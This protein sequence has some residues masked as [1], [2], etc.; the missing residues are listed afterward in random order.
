MRGLGGPSRTVWLF[1]SAALILPQAAWAQTANNPSSPTTNTLAP[2]QAPPTQAQQDAARTAAKLP[3]GSDVP[4]SPPADQ[5]TP[6]PMPAPVDHEALVPKAVK[7][8][9]IEEELIPGRRR[10]GPGRA[11]LDGRNVQFNIGA[12][13]PPELEDFHGAE[14][15]VIPD[16]WRLL[17]ALCPD[18]G[19]RAVQAA[20][21]SSLDPYHQNTLKGDRPLCHATEEENRKR[22]ENH[23]PRCI[24]PGFLHGDDWFLTLSAISDTIVEPRS[25]PLPVGVQTTDRPDSNDLFGRS[26]SFVFAQTVIASA[27]LVKGSTAYMP[28]HIEYKIALAYQYNYADVQE[29]RILNVRPSFPTHRSDAFLGV[30][31]LFVDYH[32]RNVSDRYDFDSLRVGIQPFNVDFRGFLFTDSN[33]GIRLFGNR[34][35]NR[36]QYNFAAFARLEKDSNSGLNDVTQNIRKDYVFAANLYRQ[37]FPVPGYTSQVAVVYNRNR[38]GDEIQ[39]DHNGFP[40]RPALLGDLRGREYDAYYLGYNGEGH[41]DRLNLSLS[42]YGVFGRDRNSFFTSRPANIRAFFLAAEPS[43][44]TNFIRIRGSAVYASGDGNPY[45]NT[46][47]GFDSILENPLIA[48]SDTSYF[49]RQGIPF[50]G[51]GR[52]ISFSGRNGLLNDLRSSKDEGQSNFNNPGTILAGLG[53]DI[54]VLP[55]FRVTGNANHIWFANT[56]VIQ[57]LRVEGSIPRSIGWDFSVATTYR[58]RNTQNIVFRLSGAVLAPGNGAKDLFRRQGARGPFYSILANAI[59][60]F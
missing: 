8:D 33:L 40:V 3:R 1:G 47:G 4:N 27:S 44:D 48:G 43:Y 22:R 28:P 42:A 34:D 38:E 53:A 6:A 12:V 52:A 36:W 18:R 5:L 60:T 54:D 58:P 35:N 50:I 37:D 31:E 20:C 21:H 25:F 45:N 2:P 24:T 49:I 13:S 26:S 46:E 29:R 17:A 15:V 56:K 51:G 16:R 32:L 10:P 9:P 14:A 57:A 55:T 39:V 30:Q 59:V 19:F 23:I 7:N 41:F 11:E